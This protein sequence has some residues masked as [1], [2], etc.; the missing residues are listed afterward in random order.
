MQYASFVK[1]GFSFGAALAERK[2][3]E[4]ALFPNDKLPFLHTSPRLFYFAS[5]AFIDCQR[6]LDVVNRGLVSCDFSLHHRNAFA[7]GLPAEWIY[8]CKRVGHS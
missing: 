4:V 5:N 1:D 6:R 8:Y 2:S 7:D 3:L